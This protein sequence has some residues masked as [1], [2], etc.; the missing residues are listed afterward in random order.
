MLLLKACGENAA[1]ESFRADYFAKTLRYGDLKAAVAD[2]LIAFFAPIRARRIELEHTDVD[3]LMRTH[4]LRAREIAA[5]TLR[6]VRK[7]VGI[8]Y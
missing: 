5:E 2:T 1:A 7:L 6:E 3:A 4:S 8:N